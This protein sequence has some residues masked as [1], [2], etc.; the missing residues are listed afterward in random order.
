MNDDYVFSIQAETMP[1]HFLPKRTVWQ[2]SR[3][4]HQRIQHSTEELA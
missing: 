1:I 4:E 3:L 2:P